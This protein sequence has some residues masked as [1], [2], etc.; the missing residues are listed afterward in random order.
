[1]DAKV[2]LQA[3]LVSLDLNNE[4]AR[5]AKVAEHAQQIRAHLARLGS[6]AYWD[7]L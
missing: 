5:K 4:Q 3:F 1:M 2:S 7:Q 6:K